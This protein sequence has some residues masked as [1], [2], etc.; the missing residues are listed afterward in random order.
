MSDGHI[1]AS[2]EEHSL[3]GNRGLLEKIAPGEFPR[4]CLPAD[5]QNL[6]VYYEENFGFPVPATAMAALTFL[7]AAV[8]PLVQVVGGSEYGGTA[9]NIW[10]ALIGGRSSG[11]S[12]LA[13]ALGKEIFAANAE[14]TRQFRQWKVAADTKL[15]VL[16]REMAQL[17]GGVAGGISAEETRRVAQNLEEIR[18]LKLLIGTS[19]GEAL[20]K[21]VADTPDHFTFSLCTE[22]SEAIA[23]MFGRYD[24]QR[25]PTLDAWLALKSGDFL[26]DT[27]LCRESVTV[28]RGLMA[29]LL[30]LQPGVAEKLIAQR[31]AL[32]R[33]F[34][35][36][37]FLIDPGFERRLA[38]RHKPEP[39]PRGN[40]DEIL[41]YYLQKRM[42]SVIPDLSGF[43]GPEE[44]QRRLGES[45]RTISCDGD[46]RSAFA[47]FYDEGVLLDRELSAA[48]P[49]PSGEC[50]LWR[51]DAT[52]IAGL[53]ACYEERARKSIL[54]ARLRRNGL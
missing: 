21:I 44:I 47:D 10:T 48:V 53:I 29:M 24:D 36:R 15:Q 7:S 33:G 17:R 43:Q 9:L 1:K 12:Q 54:L 18:G 27:R 2:P 38:L 39:A 34:F 14:A 49:E 52:Q 31:E 5:L 30:M 13:K 46:A 37:M 22:G 45:L 42:E 51:E 20:K 4:E 11:K 26:N 35:S 32:D 23:I 28:E 3:S 25:Q 40:Y 6:A 19:S 16:R 8:G 41:R 50:G